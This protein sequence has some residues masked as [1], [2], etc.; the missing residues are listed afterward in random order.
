[1]NMLSILNVKPVLAILTHEWPQSAKTSLYFMLMSH[2]P[3]AHMLLE[4]NKENS[5]NCESSHRTSLK[6]GSDLA[7]SVYSSVAVSGRPGFGIL[8]KLHFTVCA[9]SCQSYREHPN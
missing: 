8:Y 6:V 3:L 9:W 2:C 7:W 1:M 5:E 4:F